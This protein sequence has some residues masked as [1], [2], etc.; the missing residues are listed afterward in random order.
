V[1][2]S[3]NP[4]LGIAEA[5]RDR[6]QATCLALGHPFHR[7]ECLQ[8]EF[9][10]GWEDLHSLRW[11][12]EERYSL[13]DQIRRAIRSV[14]ANLAEAW[15]KRRY[16]AHF[17]SKLT[18]ADGEN[19]EVEHWFLPARRDGYLSDAEMNDMLE[20]KREVGRMLGTMIQKSAAISARG[21]SHPFKIVP[22]ASQSSSASCQFPVPCLLSP[23]SCLPSP[24]PCP[25]FPV[26][27]S[28]N[29]SA[30][31]HPWIASRTRPSGEI[32]LPAAV[33]ATRASRLAARD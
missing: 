30:H 32:I 31:P 28:H 9:R 29:A 11:L 26:P 18:D 14:G 24:V 22:P 7:T 17:V 12:A 6:R 15:G 4:K 20:S 1:T 2:G 23:V 5:T 21:E 8:K 3:E 13:T 10:F 25:R 33:S 16:E 19:H 27:R